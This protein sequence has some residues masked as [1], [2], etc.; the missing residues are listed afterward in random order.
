MSRFCKPVAYPIL[1]AAVLFAAQSARAGAPD[2]THAYLEGQRTI[3]DGQVEPATRPH[4]GPAVRTAPLTRADRLFLAE[5]ARTDG[6]T[7]PVVYG[8]S[9]ARPFFGWFPALAKRAR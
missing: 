4:D 8:D 7:E 6:N 2:D 5:L 1:I 3:T 9:D